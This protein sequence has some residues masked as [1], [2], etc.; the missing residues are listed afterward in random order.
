[1]KAGSEW[2][3]AAL[4]AATVVLSSCGKKDDQKRPTPEAGYIVVKAES[5][6]LPV[7]LPGR[8]SAFETSEVR[9]Q[10]TGLIKSRL[11]TEGSIVRAGETLYQI[12]PRLYRAA[13]NQANANLANAEANREATAT[14]AQRL[15]PLAK[16]EAVSQQD[17]TDARAAARQASATVEQNRA[18]L[19][20]ARINLDFTKVPAPITGRVG[21]SLFT[22][23]ALVTANQA[24]PL[25]TIQRLDPIFVDIQQSASEYLALRRALTGGGVIPSAATVKLKLEDGSD[26][27]ATG[28]LE[29]TEAMVDPTTGTVTLRARFANPTGLL[30]PGMYVRAALSQATAKS[31]ILVPQ[32][33]VARDAKGDATVM[34]VGPDNKAVQQKVTAERTI[35]DKWLVTDGLKPGDKVIVEG[36]G[37]IRQKQDIKPV[38]AGSPPAGGKEGKRG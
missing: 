13:L 21:R 28:R 2:K 8:T 7:E 26:Y 24:E 19:E 33:G 10:I 34:L 29:F 38:P 18:N 36:L 14:R 6:A 25:T 3:Y 27:P 20:T 23:G 12:D 31:A 5:V 15:E 4:L 9:P 22:T 37:K 30:L 11:F 16:I 17:Y 1:M 35:G 32:Q